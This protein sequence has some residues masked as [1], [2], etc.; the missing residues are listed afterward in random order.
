M[1]KSW[2]KVKKKLRKSWREKNV[3]RP[4]FTKSSPKLNSALWL[5]L[6]F[7]ARLIFTMVVSWRI[8]SAGVK[9]EERC[10]AMCKILSTK[11]TTLAHNVQR[12]ILFLRGRV[13]VINPANNHNK[14]DFSKPAVN[15]RTGKGNTKPTCDRHFLLG[16]SAVSALSYLTCLTNNKVI[17]VSSHHI[18]K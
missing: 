9:T 11:K 5:K 13:H 15:C 3:E 4:S 12:Q 10:A 18:I 1:K 17:C 14:D 8:L 7:W 6:Y 16:A 2:K